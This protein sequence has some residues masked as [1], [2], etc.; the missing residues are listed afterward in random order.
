[1][2]SAQI[3]STQYVFLNL[4]LS[5]GGS[6]CPSEWCI[7][8]ETIT[9]LANRIMNDATWDPMELYPKLLEQV[10]NTETMGDDIPF[11][12]GRALLVDIPIER[13]GK[14]DVYIDDV[15]TVGILSQENKRR[16]RAAVLLA[17]ETMGRPIHEKEPLPRD[18]LPSMDKLLSEAGLSEEKCLLGWVLNTRTLSIH[19]HTEKYIKWQKEIEAII[20]SK[21]E[22]S[23]KVLEVTIGR[24]NHASTILPMARH[25]LCRL[26]FITAKSCY[27]KKIYLK[28]A[29]LDDLELWMSILSKLHKGIS[30]NLITFRPP[31]RIIWTDA[32]EYGLGGYTIP[33]GRAWTFT[34]PETLRHRA[35]I[36]ILEFLAVLIGIWLDVIEGRIRKESCILAFGDNT[37]AMGWIRKSKYREECD[38]EHSMT[39]KLRIARTLA[40]LSIVH[41]FRIFSQWFPGERNH[42]A[43]FLSRHPS[44]Q[45]DGITNKILSN[46]SS[47]VP[48]D[49]KVLPLPQEIESFAYNLL[50]NLP[51]LPQRPQDTRDLDPQSGI[52]G[53]TS[54]VPSTWATTH[55]SNPYPPE[56]T[57]T[58]WFRYLLNTS[59]ETTVHPPEELKDWLKAQSEIPSACWL[60]PSWK[61]V[62][63]TQG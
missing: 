22:T 13:V 9:D 44:D 53:Q 48:K 11:T 56:D 21:G 23:K 16:L 1:M 35:H 31:D 43:D 2:S 37:T 5:F 62:S 15:C 8:S 58:K 39:A 29:I 46:F 30:M 24:L 7:I 26:S 6:A 49:F 55:S 14:A 17:M 20:K 60:R 36:N 3:G 54:S 19:L 57:G 27:Y 61:M 47:Q 52:S 10:P 18:P 28:K 63:K 32:C 4:R 34:I 59:E 33:L 41:E 50:S 51:K 45:Y 25:F 12:Q 42:I 40:S 38:S